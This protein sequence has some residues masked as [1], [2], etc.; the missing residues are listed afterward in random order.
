M[1]DYALVGFGLGQEPNFVHEFSSK[2]EGMA[3][4]R[5]AAKNC[6][7]FLLV[8][9]GPTG[10]LYTWEKNSKDEPVEIPG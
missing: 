6:E 1:Q 8:L 10:R 9:F 2:E 3:E 7:Y 5:S 4:G